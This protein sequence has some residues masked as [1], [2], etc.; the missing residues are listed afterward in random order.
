MALA[1]LS[2]T[3]DVREPS[4]QCVLIDKLVQSESFEAF[5]VN[6]DYIDEYKVMTNIKISI[7]F[8]EQFADLDEDTISYHPVTDEDRQ[9]FERQRRGLIMFSVSVKTLKKRAL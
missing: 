7:W 5:K 9:R 6:T 2:K 8:T 1:S 3:L 4:W